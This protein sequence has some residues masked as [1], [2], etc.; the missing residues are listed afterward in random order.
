MKHD[1]LPRREAD[2]LDWARNFSSVLNSEPGPGSYGVSQQ[3]AAD[4]AIVVAAYG[5]AYYRANSSARGP[6][7]VQEKNSAREP[8]SSI[9]SSA[10]PALLMVERIL[11][12]WRTIP[13]S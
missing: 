6:V 3:E 13:A 11:P 1:Y 12:W 4:Y 7:S 5:Q 8:C 10:R 2:L 9:N